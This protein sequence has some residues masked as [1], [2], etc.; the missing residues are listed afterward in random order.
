MLRN[1]SAVVRLARNT[2]CRLSRRDSTMA[3]CLESPA[4]SRCC[5]ATSRC[6]QFATTIIK[7]MVGA[8]EMG[9]ENGS[10]TQP[11]RPIEARIEKTM[12][13]PVTPTPAQLRVRTPRITAMSTRLAGRK[14]IWLLS[15]ASTKVWLTM[16]VPTVRRSMPGNR[17]SASSA[18]DLANSATSATACNR[19]S[20]GSS[21]VTFTTLTSPPSPRIVP[22]IRGS[23]KAMSRIRARVSAWGQFVGIYQVAH[24]QVVAIGGR[25]LEVGQRVDAPRVRCPPGGV[26]EPDRGRERIKRRRVAIV[27]NDQERDVLALPVGI[28]K[29]LQCQEL[30]IVFIEEDAVVGGEFEPEYAARRRRQPAPASSG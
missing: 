7:T 6:T 2:G 12:T 28:L 1:P 20:S 8:G 11:P 14:I 13:I 27:G 30:R 3:A 29:R 9:G 21:M 15:E 16:T 18:M 23:D 25:V 22:A 19:P 26:G 4:R 24:I 10:P 17:P 5:K